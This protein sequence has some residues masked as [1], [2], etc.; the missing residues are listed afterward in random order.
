M[1]P[2]PGASVPRVKGSAS[3]P[4]G[5]LLSVSSAFEGPGQQGAPTGCG[6]D[7]ENEEEGWRG[8]LALHRNLESGSVHRPGLEV[9]PGMAKGPKH[10]GLRSAF[11]RESTLRRNFSL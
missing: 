2:L 5:V 8:A 10:A 4:S 1:C 6:R 11:V 3:R 9:V 7:G